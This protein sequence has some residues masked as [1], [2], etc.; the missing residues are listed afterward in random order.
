MILRLDTYNN[1]VCS[2]TPRLSWA[3]FLR[4]PTLAHFKREL[5]T[6]NFPKG[7]DQA[8]VFFPV[9]AKVVALL[10]GQSYERVVI[11]ILE[12]PDEDQNGLARQILD[13]VICAENPLFWKEI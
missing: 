6:E 7:L 9:A 3:I 11:Q 10:T 12:G 8:Y 1:Q 4:Q 2:F 13:L 5:R